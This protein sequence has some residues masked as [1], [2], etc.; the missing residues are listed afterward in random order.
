MIAHKEKGRERKRRS[1][2]GA[3]IKG[4]SRRL[5][6]EL[7]GDLAFQKGLDKI[8]RGYA[9]V[10]ALYKGDKLYYV[11]LANNLYW[12]ILRHT[13]NRHKGKWD[14]FA[15][16]RVGRVRYLKDIETLLL[17]VAKPPGNSMSGRLHRDADLTRVIK[18]VERE[19]RRRLNRIR[20]ALS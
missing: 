18:E 13:R 3:L 5:P 9:G 12:R 15:I 2:K 16:F 8:M 6:S 17:N 7:I 19:S 11:G 20:K 10:Y 1:N 14:R 4:M